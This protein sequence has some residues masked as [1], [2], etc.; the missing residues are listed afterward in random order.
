MQANQWLRMATLFLSAKGIATA[1]LDSL[2][3]LEDVLGVDRAKLLAEPNMEITDG[4]IAALQNLLSRR[5]QHEP[6]AYIRGRSEFYGRVF[7]ISPAVL[8]PRPESETMIDLLKSLTD[9]PSQP[10]IADVGSGSGVLGI[11]AALELPWAMVTLLEIDPAA[12]EI[13][14]LNVVLQTT[15]ISV[16]ISDL[17]ATTPQNYDVL[18]CNL[19]YVPDDFVINEAAHHE[20]ALALFSGPDGLEVYRQLFAQLMDFQNK[21]LFI[22]TEAF[23]D[24]HDLLEALAETLGYKLL[25]AE[26]FIQV[27]QLIN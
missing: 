8:V 15:K 13:A 16:I 21:P 11:T 22:L 7:K 12:A 4:A 5:A 3:L 2:V 1:R 17:L 18:L 20:P 6:L 26:D 19:P 9:L 27:F 14:K 23:P 10:K 25:Q 24:Q